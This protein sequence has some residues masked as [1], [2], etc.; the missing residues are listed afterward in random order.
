MAAKKTSTET[1]PPAELSFEDALSR[2]EVITGQLEGDDL[3][4]DAAIASFEEGVSLLRVCE[5]RQRGA[6]G[7]L[8]ELSRGENGELVERLLG[9]LAQSVTEIDE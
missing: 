3:P 8:R 5:G 4:L 7:R 9:T 1:L 2:L 6:E